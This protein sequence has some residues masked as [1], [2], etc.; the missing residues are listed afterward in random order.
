MADKGIEENL[1]KCV[2]VIGWWHNDK[3]RN[4]EA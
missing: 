1:D 4:H 3:E 2:K